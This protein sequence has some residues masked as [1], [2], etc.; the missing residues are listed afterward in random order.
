MSPVHRS[1][2]RFNTPQVIGDFTEPF[3]ALA[4]VIPGSL[5]SQRLMTFIVNP[6]HRLPVVRQV[7]AVKILLAVWAMIAGSLHVRA[8]SVSLRLDAQSGHG[9]LRRLQRRFELWRQRDQQ[10]DHSRLP[11][12][13]AHVLRQDVLSV[14]QK[15]LSFLRPQNFAPRCS[16]I[17]PNSAARG[18]A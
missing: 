9:F 7:A 14:P 16:M 1:K 10:F 12:K 6:S 8:Q 3:L 15:L 11:A 13:W 4:R 5:R 17:G 18:F 2:N